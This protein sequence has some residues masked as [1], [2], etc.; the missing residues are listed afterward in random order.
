MWWR[1]YAWPTGT[2]VNV[3]IS[4]AKL[5]YRFKI[6]D[7]AMVS[8]YCM[9]WHSYGIILGV[10]PVSRAYWYFRKLTIDMGSAKED[11]Y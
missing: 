1:P 8:L 9:Q 2:G 7:S 10:S 11:E 6:I 5:A 3:I 4:I